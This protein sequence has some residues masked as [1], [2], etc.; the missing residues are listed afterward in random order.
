MGN[1]LTPLSQDE[2]RHLPP[3]VPNIVMVTNASDK[4]VDNSINDL[5]TSLWLDH[6]ASHVLG[7][8]FEQDLDLPHDI[9]TPTRPGNHVDIVYPILIDLTQDNQ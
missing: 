2:A 5:M 1:E 4:S 6:G 9:I 8:E 7:F 3:A